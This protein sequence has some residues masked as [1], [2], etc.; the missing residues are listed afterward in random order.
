[1]SGTGEAGK[2]PMLDLFRMESQS[3]L[4]VLTDGLQ[5]VKEDLQNTDELDTLA[6]ASRSLKGAAKIAHLEPA[7]EIAQHLEDIFSAA[8][9]HAILLTAKHVTTLTKATDL[10]TQLT[11]AAEGDLQGWLEKNVAKL[12]QL[13]QSLSTIRASTSEAPTETATAEPK[14]EFKPEPESGRSIL[15]GL[16]FSG[17]DRS[18]RWI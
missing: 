12:E 5:A 7:F 2:N 16:P 15:I 4:S 13:L 9:Q 14:A 6:R 10:L 8:Q 17:F 1:M 11:Q 18:D 3:Q